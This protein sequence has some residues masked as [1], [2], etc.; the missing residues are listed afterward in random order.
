MIPEWLLCSLKYM[1][2]DTAQKVASSLLAKDYND[3]HRKDGTFAPKG[4]GNSS[5]RMIRKPGNGKEKGKIHGSV[6][7]KARAS[8][9]IKKLTGN[10]LKQKAKEIRDRD[11]KY[12]YLTNGLNGGG[13]RSTSGFEHDRRREHF[14]K[15]GKDM[16]FK[17][18]KEYEKAGMEFMGQ[19]MSEYME[20]LDCGGDEIVRYDYEN[21]LIGTVR[22]DGTLKTFYDPTKSRT[23]KSV[24]DCFRE[25]MRSVEKR[26]DKK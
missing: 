9:K 14:D 3:K 19:P 12:P 7:R 2:R 4:S 21:S 17:N 8:G 13:A 22:R 26:R 25:K 23:P 20:E 1:D 6:L 18:E 11:G 24:E 5:G 10:A 16:G 15:H